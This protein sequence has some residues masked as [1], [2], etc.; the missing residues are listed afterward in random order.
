VRLD[1]ELPY[2]TSRT[3]KRKW[4]ALNQVGFPQRSFHS[5]ITYGKQVIAF[6]GRDLHNVNFNDLYTATF[7]SP[8]TLT[9]AT[10]SK[11]RSSLTLTHRPLWLQT[12]AR[13]DRAQS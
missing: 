11:L 8:P 9:H 4:K 5:A 12:R 3:E 6:G 10:Q 2:S 7:G 1:V 13:A